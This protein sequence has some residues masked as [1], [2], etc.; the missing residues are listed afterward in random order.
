[1]NNYMADIRR[2]GEHEGGGK[3][4]VSNVLSQGFLAITMYRFFN[5][6]S[7]KRISCLIFRFPVEKLVEVICGISLPAKC[8]VGS[9]LRIHH[10]GGIVI[11]ESVKIGKNATLY[12][13]VT[14]GLKKDD[15]KKGPVI[16][17]NVYIGAGAKV[18]GAIKIG[19]DVKIGANAVVLTDVPDNA[20][21]V[22]V[23]A[24]IMLK[25]NY[26]S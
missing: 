8:E 24:R 12:H 19:N 21:A 26:E 25:V 18:L 20:V 4:L 17:D 16:G 7:R 5:F 9:G 2:L 14:L 11:H 3:R 15:E 13:G 1:M 6:L 23:P 10:F 22:G